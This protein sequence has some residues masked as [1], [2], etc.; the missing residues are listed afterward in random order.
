MLPLPFYKLFRL[1]AL[2]LLALIL[3]LPPAAAA[4]APTLAAPA[5]APAWRGEYFA[6]QDLT[7]S[8]AFVRADP[9]L[10]FDWGW[11]APDRR[12]AA[13]HFSVRWTRNV[14]FPAGEFRFSATVDDGIR[15]YVDGETIIDQ[16]RVTAPITYTSSISLAA[17]TH[18]LKVEYFENTERAQVHVWWDQNPVI[19]VSAPTWQPPNHPGA[20]L[21]TYYNNRSLSGD[22]AFQRNDAVV[23][24]DWGTGG[25]GGGVGGQDFSARW[26]RVVEFSG[27]RYLFTV[28][29]DDG[30]RVWFDW[31]LI[32]DQ[33]HDSPGATYSVEKDVKGGNHEIVVEYYQGA[34]DAEVKFEWQDTSVTWVGNLSTCMRPTSSWIK[35][36]RLAPNNTWEDLKPEGWG[37]IA[38]NGELKLFGLPVSPFYGWDGQP[39]KVELWEDGALVRTEGD[40]L[41]GQKVLALQPAGAI[42]TSWPCGANIPQK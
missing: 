32:I 9:N 22:A 7:G 25:P 15:V 12:L 17:G 31:A 29:A 19:P 16:W 18:A 39:Y 11:G 30:V 3:T 6:S 20:W 10:D 5:T 40:V 35:I 21:G 36:Y 34:G 24:F 41:A 2:V 8:P 27:G 26:D 13:D 4:S 33:W 42:Q 37:P 23:Y 1:S 38:Q 14:D 28:T